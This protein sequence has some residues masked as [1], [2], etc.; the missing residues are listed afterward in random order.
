MMGDYLI[1]NTLV[2]VP[3]VLPYLVDLCLESSIEVPIRL[4]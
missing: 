1:A 4:L 2:Y 3:F